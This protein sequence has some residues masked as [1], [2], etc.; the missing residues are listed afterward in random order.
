MKSISKLFSNN[1]HSEPKCLKNS[2]SSY[3]NY[4]KVLLNILCSFDKYK[5]MSHNIYFDFLKYKWNWISLLMF[6][7]HFNAFSINRLSRFLIFIFKKY[8][9]IEGYIEPFVIWIKI[10][11]LV[12][13][14]SLTLSINFTTQKFILLCNQISYYFSLWLQDCT[15]CQS[16][17]SLQIIITFTNDSFSWKF[18]RFF[19]F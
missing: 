9:K 1:S 12:C 4:H 18:H 6:I 7:N 13:H 3:F 16:G 19:S 5:L 10:F 11:F 2:V 17:L 14:L 8:A 15:I